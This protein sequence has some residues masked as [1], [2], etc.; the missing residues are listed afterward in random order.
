M[1]IG[2]DLWV[3]G[4]L[5][6][7]NLNVPS[8]GLRHSSL[9]NVSTLYISSTSKRPLTRCHM[10][11]FYIKHPLMASMAT[12][13]A[14]LPTLYH[15]GAIWDSNGTHVSSGVPQ[16]SVLGPS[17]FL[18]NINDLF[19]LFKDS[20]WGIPTKVCLSYRRCCTI[21]DDSVVFEKYLICCC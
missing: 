9:S 12:S 8:N 2:I 19:N 5:Q 21:V 3:A 1:G 16:G 7:I 11:N 18:L 14:G 17:L 13:G 20:N 10:T 4:L 6:P 15:W